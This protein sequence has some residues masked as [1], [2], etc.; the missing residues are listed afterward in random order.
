M[1]PILDF[2]WK[3]FVLVYGL[4]QTYGLYVAFRE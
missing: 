4:K 2:D 1:R 3:I